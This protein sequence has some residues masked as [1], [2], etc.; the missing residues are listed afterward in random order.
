MKSAVYLRS[1]AATSTP[2]VG[3]SSIKGPQ[4][5]RHQAPVRAEPSADC[6]RESNHWKFEIV[7]PNLKIANKRTHTLNLI[8]ARVDRTR[9]RNQ[10]NVFANA[11]V[12]GSSRRVADPRAQAQACPQSIAHASGVQV[13]VANNDLPR[14]QLAMARQRLQQ[15]R[16]SCSEEAVNTDDFASTK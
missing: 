2:R 12:E 11:E 9:T 3:S 13:L 14:F 7:H 1:F 15:L 8:P 6:H 5:R 16:T 4:D 10:S